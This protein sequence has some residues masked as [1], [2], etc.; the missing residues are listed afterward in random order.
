MF[1]LDSNIQRFCVAAMQPESKEVKRH[2]T[3][4]D[5]PWYPLIYH[6]HKALQALPPLR[7]GYVFRGVHRHSPNERGVQTPFKQSDV[8]QMLKDFPTEKEVR[9]S[10]FTTCTPSLHVAAAWALTDSKTS[11]TATTEDG[12]VTRVEVKDGGKGHWESPPSVRIV[13]DGQGAKAVA[14]VNT[15]GVVTHVDVMSGGTG[16]TNAEVEFQALDCHGYGVVFKIRCKRRARDVA[17]FSLTPWQAPFLRQHS[18]QFPAMF[19]RQG[20]FS[21]HLHSSAAH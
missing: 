15:L 3:S 21:H 19:H 11:A 20:S 7:P 12:C 9:W 5:H 6:T 14:V 8:V 1:C 17:D 2:K 13:G 4:V 16:Y 10:G 18:V